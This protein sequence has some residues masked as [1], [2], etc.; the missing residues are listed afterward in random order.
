MS[1]IEP[2]LPTLASGP[3][4]LPAARG[5]WRWPGLIRASAGIHL[6]AGGALFVPGAE[7]WGIGALVANHALLTATGLWPR[8]RGLGPNLTRLPEASASGGEVAITI[9]DGP[10]PETTP[11]VLELLAKHEVK[12][13]FFCIGERALAHRALMREIVAAGHDVQNHSQHHRHLF[14][15]SGPRA[16]RREIEGAQETLAELTG[17]RPHCFRAPAGL[18]N[19]LLDPVL[20]ALGLNLVSWTR[21]GFD[22]READ[23]GRVLSRLLRGLRGGDILLMHDGHA[24]RTPAGSAVLLEALPPLLERCRAAGLQPVTLRDAV[25]PRHAPA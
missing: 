4:D 6:A 19:P 10:D 12:A 17:L 8:S 24:R 15:L 16:L 3:A 21:R 13:T 20:H 9:D 18:R 1:S 7:P 14:S 23:A 2:T 22:T 5:R 25:P 11:A